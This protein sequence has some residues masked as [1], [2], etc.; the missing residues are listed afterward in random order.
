MSRGSRR[1]HL[2]D[3]CAPLDEADDEVDLP[4]N[5]ARIGDSELALTA[6]LSS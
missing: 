5:I 4:A 6:R 3:Q 1:D 2:P